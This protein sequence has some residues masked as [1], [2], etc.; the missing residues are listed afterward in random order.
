METGPG[1]RI[2]SIGPLTSGGPSP[3][4][5]PSS[6]PGSDVPTVLEHFPGFVRCVM[7]IAP[8]VVGWVIGRSGSHIK[9]SKVSHENLPSTLPR[10]SP[11]SRQDLERM[12]G[13]K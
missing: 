10:C 13:L 7:P 1:H 5:D 9:D 4:E 12:H 6:R 8:E 2:G 11:H 3:P